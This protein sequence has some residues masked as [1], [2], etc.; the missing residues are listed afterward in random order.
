MRTS[1]FTVGLA[2]LLGSAPLAAVAKVTQY[3]C[4]FAQERRGGGWVPEVVYIL[5][6]DS[7]GTIEAYDPIIDAFVGNPIPAKMTGDTDVR[8][9]FSW[10]L[11]FKNKGQGG[12]MDYTLTYFADGRPAKMSAKPGG[13]DNRWGG[14]GSCSVS[15]K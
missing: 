1:A 14:E 11:Q 6:D 13:Y 12:I 5:V 2:V 8:K 4:K 7:A 15:T 3:E 10:K 9:T